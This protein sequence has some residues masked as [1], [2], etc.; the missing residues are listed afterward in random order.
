MEYN[1][2]PNTQLGFIEIPNQ[3]YDDENAY[4]GDKYVRSGEYIENLVCDNVVE[5]C[6]RWLHLA[7]FKE[8]LEDWAEYN[9][10]YNYS[11]IVTDPTGK[12]IINGRLKIC[13]IYHV[14]NNNKTLAIVPITKASPLRFYG[15]MKSSGVNINELNKPR[16]IDLY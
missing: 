5:F 13:P 7:G 9:A 16:L 3:I 6:K 14:D 15:D 1:I 2:A 10:R 4:K 11:T 12:Q 8:F